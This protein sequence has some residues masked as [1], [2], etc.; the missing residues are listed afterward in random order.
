MCFIMTVLLILVTKKQGHCIPLLQDLLLY[1]VKSYK[2][3]GLFAT[4]LSYN[5]YYKREHVKLTWNKRWKVV[6]Y[7]VYLCYSTAVFFFLQ[8]RYN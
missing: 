8:V 5:L 7:K 3:V 4:N 6:A 2:C 1:C